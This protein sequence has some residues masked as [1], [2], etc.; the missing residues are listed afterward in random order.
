MYEFYVD[1][2]EVRE[3]LAEVVERRSG[4]TENMLEIVYQPQAKFRVQPVTHCSSS[5]PGERGGLSGWNECLPVH[6][7]VHAVSTVL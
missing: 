2:L 7:P 5:I 3:S 4:N 6:W 1:D